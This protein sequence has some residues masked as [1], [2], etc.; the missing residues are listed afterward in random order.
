[1]SRVERTDRSVTDIIDHALVIARRQ[2]AA[3]A[4]ARRFVAATEDAIRK[5]ADMPCMGTIRES[6]D[7]DLIGLRQWPVKG[8]RNF[9]VI[10][11]HSATAS[12]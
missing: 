4:A 11:R 6:S 3:A 5:L 12:S 8:F 9:L 10:Y 1:M 7:P 2:P